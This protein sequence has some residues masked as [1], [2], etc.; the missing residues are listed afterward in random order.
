MNICQMNCSLWHFFVFDRGCHCVSFSE[1]NCLTIYACF[2]QQYILKINKQLH[3]TYNICTIFCVLLFSSTS[4]YNLYLFLMNL[5]CLSWEVTVRSSWYL[6]L[7]IIGNLPNS[8][9][10]FQSLVPPFHSLYTLRQTHLLWSC[11]IC[12]TF[13][14]LVFPCLW[15]PLHIYRAGRFWTE[16]RELMLPFRMIE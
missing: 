10:F 11:Y 9:L 12:R 1:P 15:I 13:W 14:L 4:F 5:N 3:V 6:L 16:G 2:S 8:S 7:H